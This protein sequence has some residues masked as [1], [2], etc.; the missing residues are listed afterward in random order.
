[1]MSECI[2]Y[3]C[4]RNRQHCAPY[5]TDEHE[6]HE[7]QPLVMDEEYGCE[8]SRTEEQAHP[9]CLLKGLELGDHECPEHRSDGFNGKEHAHPV[10]GSL[11]FG[12]LDIGSPPAAVC[13]GTV[14]VGPEVEERRPA[15]ELYEADRPECL[16]RL[17]QKLHK[18]GVLLFDIFFDTV[19]LGIFPRIEFLDLKESKEHAEDEYRGAAIETPFDRIG[20]D[21]LG[22]CIGNT[23]PREE[24]REKITD[25]ASGIAEETLCAVCLRFLLLAH[26]IAY[27]H[28]EWLHGD[29]DG[30][31]KEYET[32][33]SEPHRGIKSEEYIRLAQIQTSCIGKQ[34]HHEHCDNGAD[35]KIGLTPA[36][37]APC[38]IGPFADEG[39]Y[40]HAHQRRKYPEKAQLVRV[41]SEGREYAGNV[42]ALKRIGN[43]DSEK[44]EVEIEYLA[45]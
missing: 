16:G 14:G 12:G 23:N 19:E 10:A 41:R 37:A 4:E 36:E 1:M 15:E 31:V 9:I 34:K 42:C 30:S 40:Y 27:H 35:K 45:E 44:A 26:H 3:E 2:G 5:D 20:D 22:G 32:E 21:S 28:L 33:E 25:K 39:L 8:S 17:K 6:A 29:I 43:L 13:N 24:N 18:T 38:T 7:E 11:I